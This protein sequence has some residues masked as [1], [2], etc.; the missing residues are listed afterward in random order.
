MTLTPY[1]EEILSEPAN[2]ENALANFESKSLDG[3][4]KNLLEGQFDR[5]VLTGMGASLY[6]LYPTWISLTSLAI[7]V[8]YVDL[9]ELV[10]FANPLITKKTLLWV[11]SQSGRTAE[12]ET[13][14]DREKFHPAYFLATVNDLGSPL[15]KHADQYLPINAEVEKTVSTRTYINSLVINQLAA[16]C[17]LG[18]DIQPDLNIFRRTVN[19][20]DTYLRA[21]D[22]HVSEF[23]DEIGLPTHLALI[24]RGASL[25]SA[26]MGALM[27][28]EAA[29]FPALA[30]NAGQFRHGP[31]EMV[32]ENLT[33][34][35]MAGAQSTRDLNFRLFKDLLSFG[36]QGFWLSDKTLESTPAIQ[37]P[38]VEEIALP[39]MEI[40][41]LQLLSISI[42]EQRGLE[43][44]KFFRI[45]KVTLKE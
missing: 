33:A 4:G 28:H 20:L 14:Y 2:L 32:D 10:H 1:K 11:V 8:L 13:L 21:M 44:G 31:I 43:A 3:L 9:A 16:K 29:K 42:A 23:I 5:V 41:A 45:G 30:Y 36:A 26:W 7:P 39:V 6:S 24:A 40:V 18:M 38:S 35:V 15:A 25:A 22:E 12:L 37:I 19:L 27:M 17:L 34:I